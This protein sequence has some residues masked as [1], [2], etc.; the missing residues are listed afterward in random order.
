[1]TAAFGRLLYT[2]CAPGTGRGS[3]GGFQIQAQSPSVDPQ[4]ASFAVGWL[5]YEA[6]NA[7]VADRRP[8]EDFPL[9]FAHSGA[10]GYGTAQGR[11]LGKEAVG[12]RMGNHLADCL[13][14]RDADG[15]DTIRPAQLWRAPLWRSE[16]WESRDCPDYDGD[17]EPGPLGLEHVTDWVRERAERAPALARLLSVLEDRKGQRVVI[18]SADADEAMRWITAATLLLPQRQAIEVSFKVFSAAPLRS[19]Q[20]V[21]AAPPD[22][23]PDLR[24]G[25]GLGVFVLEAATCRCDEADVTRR[26]EFLVGKFAGDS[27]PYDIVD[28]NDLALTLGADAWPLDVA[29]LHA[30]W[31]LTCPDDQVTDPDALFRWL[32]QA[33]QEHLREHGQAITEALLA[34]QASGDQ[35]RWLDARVGAGALPF[36]HDVIRMRLLDAE[37]TDVLAGRPAPAGP[38]PDAML[39]E[40]ARRDAESALTSALLRGAD[41][42]FDEAGRVLR[43]ARRHGISL[44]PLSPTVEKFVTDFAWAWLSSSKPEDPKDWALREHILAE[45]QAELR[46]RYTEDPSSKAVRDTMRR[47]FPYLR[48]LNDPVDPLYWPL[49]AASIKALPGPEKVIRLRKMLASADLLRRTDQN[50]ALRAEQALQRALL[51]WD[52]VDEGVAITIIT[53]VSASQVNQEIYSYAQSWLAGKARNPDRDLLTVLQNLGDRIPASPPELA[54]L[55]D[56]NRK[57]AQFI[58]AATGDSIGQPRTRVIA[59][60]NVCEADPV[61]VKILAAEVIDALSYDPDLAADVFARF[62]SRSKKESPIPTLIQAVDSRFG[63]LAEFE[64]RVQCALWAFQIYAHPHL[65][66]TRRGWMAKEIRKFQS[67]II[68]AEG[69]KSADNWRAVVRERLASGD[70]RD[71]W[72]SLLPKQ[73]PNW[74]FRG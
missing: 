8:I 72:D 69:A 6:Q 27:D 59:I 1:M 14:T 58:K 26:A 44:E 54:E 36:D 31:A 68:A 55:A 9:G 35:L 29:A 25:A 64:D 21:V 42:K 15:Y 37:I 13:L 23:N 17:L 40:Q 32:Q 28:A 7:W 52:A 43:L 53:E 49:Q 20:R 71:Q 30:A 63:E 33:S 66:D 48:E 12:G 11:Y 56:G 24:P 74:V 3:G 39:T 45:A 38:L 57:V 22:V 67:L 60:K 18:M 2:D 73:G 61:V 65:S 16:P 47:V 4:Q 50:L 10:E 41:G 46:N 62:P 34:G 5:L 19:L 51:D 70:L